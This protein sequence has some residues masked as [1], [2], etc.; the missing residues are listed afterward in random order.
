MATQRRF[1]LSSSFLL[2]VL[3]GWAGIGAAQDKKACQ[4][5]CTETYEQCRQK[6]DANEAQCMKY[7][8]PGPNYAICTKQCGAGQSRALT[9]CQ[10]VQN[11]CQSK[12]STSNSGSNT[13]KN[14]KPGAH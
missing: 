12:C 1:F 8:S 2:L 9:S 13:G 5:S 11:T 4:A 6:A 10:T 7:C 14:N 3:C